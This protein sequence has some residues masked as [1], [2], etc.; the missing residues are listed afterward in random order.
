[1]ETK[2]RSIAKAISWRIIAT[3]ITSFLVLFLTGAWE[4][5]ATV[6]LADTLLKFF[7]YF[8]HERMWNRVRYGLDEEQPE[9]TI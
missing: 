9:Y 1:M 6:G 2:K 5:A 3:I 7:I 8:A 4:F